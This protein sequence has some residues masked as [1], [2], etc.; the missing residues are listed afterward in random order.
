V[1]WRSRSAL[2]RRAEGIAAGHRA[3]KLEAP[4]WKT[5]VAV[6]TNFAGWTND[7]IIRDWH[8]TPRTV[9]PPLLWPNVPPSSAPRARFRPSAEG[10]RN[11]VAG[12][13]PLCAPKRPRTRVGVEGQS[14][15][16][17]H[18]RRSR[19]AF[20]SGSLSMRVQLISSI[21][22]GPPLMRRRLSSARILLG[23][24]RAE[25]PRDFT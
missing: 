4:G 16:L 10:S 1:T 21:I 25:M 8:L 7:V 12:F 11:L 15:Y 5:A 24:D 20:R 22:Y 2:P 6:W 9:W 14:H 19:T 17:R 13:S 23:R 3:R 18:D